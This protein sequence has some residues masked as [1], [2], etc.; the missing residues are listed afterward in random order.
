M[1][2]DPAAL[3]IQDVNNAFVVVLRR[4]ARRFPDINIADDYATRIRI[5]RIAR[6]L[7]AASPADPITWYHRARSM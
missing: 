6:R 3:P 5:H 4:V 7:V 2:R 1:R